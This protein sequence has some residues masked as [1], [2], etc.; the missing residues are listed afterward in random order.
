MVALCI[1]KMY[2]ETTNCL[3]TIQD[4]TPNYLDCL[5]FQRDFSI[6]STVGEYC[7]SVFPWHEY[8]TA[9]GF[10]CWSQT[11]RSLRRLRQSEKKIQSLV[12]LEVKVCKLLSKRY[13]HASFF[14]FMGAK[15]KQLETFLLI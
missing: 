14:F 4:F 7:W 13:F 8:R 12:G 10:P 1:S 9:Q 11:P 3:Q 6:F 5:V 2:L 15:I